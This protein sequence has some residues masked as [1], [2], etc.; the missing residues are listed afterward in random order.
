L[1]AVLNAFLIESEKNPFKPFVVPV[2][3]SAADRG[4]YRQ[5][6]GPAA[7]RGTKMTAYLILFI[8]FLPVA[9]VI[10][11]VLR[12]FGVKENVDGELG[13]VNIAGSMA[14][15]VICLAYFG[16]IALTVLSL[17]GIVD[18]HQLFCAWHITESNC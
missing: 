5:A 16:L 9:L 17:L 14:I 12:K 8:A 6:A 18:G 15:L 10:W 2:L 4:E 13:V 11:L 1:I 3:R 7:L